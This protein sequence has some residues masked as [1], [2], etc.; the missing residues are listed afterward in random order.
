MGLSFW[1]PIF[2]IFFLAKGLNYTEIMIM[3]VITAVFQI[4]LEVPS[5][6]YADYFGRKNC[7][8]IAAVCRAVN[9]GI[10]IFADHFITFAISS[11]IF[12]ATIAFASGS[13]S[14]F[15]YDTL[16]QIKKEHQFKKIE[17]KAFSYSL[18]A[19]GIGSFFG[20][21]IAEKSLLIPLILTVIANIIAIIVAFSLEEPNQRKKSS[22]TDYFSHL[23]DATSFTLKHPKVKWFVL[24]SGLMMGAMIISHKFVQPYLQL[25]GIA[26]S[27]FGALYLIW[28]VTS[29]L[30]AK[31]AGGIE[32]QLEENKSLILIVVILGLQFLIM[33]WN[34]SLFGVL[35]IFLGQ[36][37]WGFLRPVIGDYINRHVESHHRA[38]VLSLEGFMQ[39]VFIIALGPLFGYLADYFSIAYALFIEGIVVLIAG[40]IIIMLLNT[41]KNKI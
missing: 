5:G 30:I 18:I 27:Y 19:M 20:G 34:V 31:M 1:V 37:T 4:V 35:A 16:K 40:F 3:G 32:E 21:L 9:L 6:I 15:I 7:M 12:G 38:T 41:S 14:A 39:S 11:A 26:L 36:F 25:N 33:G 17:G 13:T 24:F 28:L 29:A 22:D 10:F 8:A 2:I 23:K